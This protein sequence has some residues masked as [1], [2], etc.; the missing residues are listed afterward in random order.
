MINPE[1]ANQVKETIEEGHAV[2]V[3]ATPTTF[4]NGR[5]VIGPDKSTIEQN[6]AFAHPTQ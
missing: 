3:T 2:T 5:R 4:V 6:V 1:T